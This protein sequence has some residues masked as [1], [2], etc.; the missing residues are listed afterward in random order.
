MHNEEFPRSS[1]DPDGRGCGKICE[2]MS[3]YFKP[4]RRKIGVLTLV[5]ACVL[6]VGWIRGRYVEEIFIPCGKGSSMHDFI[7]SGSGVT[8]YWQAI[9]DGEITSEQGWHHYQFPRK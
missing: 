4:L 9:D 8:W 6:M 3:S 2:I 7:F 5:M 1:V